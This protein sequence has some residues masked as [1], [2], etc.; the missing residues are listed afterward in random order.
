MIHSFVATVTTFPDILKQPPLTIVNASGKTGLAMT[1]AL[2]LH[3]IG[4]PVS[5]D[6]L[7][8]QTEKAEKTFIRYNSDIIQMDN[9]LLSALSPVFSGEKRPATPEEK[10][11]M[12]GAYELVLGKDASLYF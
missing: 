2:K 11:T 7:R 3:S 9:I 5:E 10:L 1:V 8:N 6:N 12:V 4:F